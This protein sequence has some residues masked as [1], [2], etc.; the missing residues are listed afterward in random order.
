MGNSSRLYRMRKKAVIPAMWP[1]P[2]FA[3]CTLHGHTR[4]HTVLPVLWTVESPATRL[5]VKPIEETPAYV[6]CKTC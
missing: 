2:W 4:P 5:T 3:A 1:R 6:D